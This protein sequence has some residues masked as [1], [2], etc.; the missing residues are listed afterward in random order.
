MSHPVLVINNVVFWGINFKHIRINFDRVPA[1]NAAH[2]ETVPGSIRNSGVTVS[3]LAKNFKFTKIFM[4]VRV[5]E[6]GMLPESNK[7]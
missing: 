6:D 7:L 3:F 4:H 5:V 1:S 2:F